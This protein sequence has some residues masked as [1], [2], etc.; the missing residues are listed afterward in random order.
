MH[1]DDIKMKLKYAT[2]TLWRGFIIPPIRHYQNIIQA[3]DVAYLKD[4]GKCPCCLK[5][6]L[7]F[8][9]NSGIWQASKDRMK[10]GLP[11]GHKE[12]TVRWCCTCCNK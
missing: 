2:S 9:S 4:N 3:M 7:I 1:S 8:L 12:Q 6:N 11:Y 10:R 5:P